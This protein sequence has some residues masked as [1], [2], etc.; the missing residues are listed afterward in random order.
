MALILI[1]GASDGLGRAL[2]TA[3]ADQGHHLI[4]HGRDAARLADVAALTGATPIRADLSSLAEVRRL[5][6]AVPEG[7]DVLVNNAGVGFGA[8]GAGRELS[9]D[10]YEL[11]LAVNYLAPYLLTKLVLP[12][13]ARETPARIVNVASVGQRPL[14]LADPMM[15]RGYDGVEA[16]RRSKLALIAHT[17]D[18]AEELAGTLVTANCLHPAS[19][20]PTT[21][22]RE[23]GWGEIDTLEKGLRATLR[24]VVDPQLTG[25][26]GRYFDGERE[27]RA[28]DQAYDPEFRKQL[29][30][31]T[32]SLIGR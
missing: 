17:F 14:D 26:T 29:R 10:G 3:L 6:E 31:L 2:A 30:E 7:L 24:L 22:V 20:M 12:R 8:P 5:A 9:A 1:T 11:R 23:A 19:L 21:M 4:V 28:L 18:L 15:E 32:E 27:A 13:M 25:V 16:Y